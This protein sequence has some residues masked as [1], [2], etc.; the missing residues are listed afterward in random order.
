M[1]G[2]RR[3]RQALAVYRDSQDLIQLGAYVAGSNPVLDSSIRLRPEL[4]EFLRQDHAT[5]STRQ[6][7]LV[8]ARS[9]GGAPGSRP[10][11]S[12]RPAGGEIRGHVSLPVSVGESPR[13]AADAA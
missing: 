3:L 8:A 11:G 12:P 5:N 2:A 9:T 4:M 6:E 1:D 10:A 7:T 13:V